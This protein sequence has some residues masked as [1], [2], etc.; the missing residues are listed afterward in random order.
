MQ[1]IQ[2][3]PDV[4]RWARETS[5]LTLDAAAHKLQFKPTG[6]LSPAQKL[7]SIE[8]GGSEVTRPLLIKMSKQYHRP[9]IAFYLD[10]PPIKGDRGQDFRQTSECYHQVDEGLVDSL[11][12]DVRVRQNIL[13]SALEDEDE[14]D[15]LPFVGTSSIKDGLKSISNSICNTL[16]FSLEEFRLQKDVASAFTYLRN[17]VEAVGV[18]VL[19]IGDL[20]SHHTKISVDAFRGFAIADNV[21]P[22]VIINDHDSRSAWSFTLLHELAHIWLGQTG[23]SGA[24][25]ENEIEKFCNDVASLILL[26][27]HELSDLKVFDQTE[28]SEAV[29]LISSFA[30]K[31]RISRSMVAYRLYRSGIINYEKWHL[32]RTEFKDQWIQ[33]H[34]IQKKINATHD[35][36][37]PTYYVVRRNRIGKALIDLV[38][39]MILSGTLTSTKAGKVLG[40]KPR[41][42]FTLIQK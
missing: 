22:F 5:G 23:I 40:I 27:S 26:P 33:K 7:E 37:G 3:N 4:L 8:S 12:R 10:S 41:N 6:K 17:K 34:A 24:F 29:H 21:A 19:I 32:L 14:A 16:G 15:K 30:E 36:N 39:R 25:S 13:R 1:S 38:S 20:G 28:C 9:L 18:F 11:V 2:I 35:S 42:V 31:R